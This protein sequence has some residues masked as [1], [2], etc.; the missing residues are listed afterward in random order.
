MSRGSP[1]PNLGDSS[2]EDVTHEGAKVPS[3]APSKKIWSWLHI[4]VSTGNIEKVFR[5]Y[6]VPFPKSKFHT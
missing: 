4:A 1:S 3:A 6:P 2:D 5:V